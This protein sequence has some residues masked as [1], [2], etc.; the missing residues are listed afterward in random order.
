VNNPFENIVPRDN[1]LMVN[2]Q[3]I[4]VIADKIKE[5]IKNNRLIILEGSYGIGKSLYL[6]RLFKRLKTKKDLIEFSDTIISV[7]E[8]KVP[9]KN[10][11][12]FIN[13]FD[14]IQGLNEKQLIRLTEVITKHL[15]E[16]VIFVVACR[17]DTVNLLLKINP[18]FH[19]KVNRLRLPSLSF[20][21]TKE[22]IINRLNEARKKKSDSLSPFTNDELKLFWDK[23]KGNP[24]M[25]L[26]LLNPLYE[27]RMMLKY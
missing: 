27:Q 8:S 2:E 14:L 3:S 16:G 21:E 17:K 25:L 22:L 26:L 7:L 18:L 20:N 23:S 15:N 1:E 9:V 4:N 13:N 10:K 5:R 11:T 19:S 24:R 12:F 6:D